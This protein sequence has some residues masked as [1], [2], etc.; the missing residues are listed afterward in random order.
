MLTNMCFEVTLNTLLKRHV[1]HYYQGGNDMP[2]GIA[3]EG[4]ASLSLVD[5]GNERGT[6]KVF[7]TVLTAGNFVA[8]TGLWDTLIGTSMAL[9]LGAKAR[10]VYGNVHNYDYDQPTNGAAREIALLVQYKDGTT[11]QRFTAKLPTLDPT[12]PDYIVSINAKDVIKVDSPSAITDFITAFNAFVK[13]PY[14]TNAC[15]VIGLKVV[16]GGK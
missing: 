8:Q 9:V 14:T 1:K 13:N 6:F 12:I 7:G 16:R 3:N 10:M 2:S 15:E 4:L 11:G 5:A